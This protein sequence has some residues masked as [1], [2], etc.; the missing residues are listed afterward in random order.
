M[1]AEPE[2]A[3]LEDVSASISEHYEGSS[4]LVRIKPNLIAL[5]NAPPTSSQCMLNSRRFWS[6]RG[7]APKCLHSSPFQEERG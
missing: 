4:V 6:V 1:G 3:E 5:R 7:S 2:D